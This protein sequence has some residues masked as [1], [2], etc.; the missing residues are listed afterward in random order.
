[1]IMSDKIKLKHTFDEPGYCQKHYR[2]E[3]GYNYIVQY[4]YGENNAPTM[5]TCSGDPDWLEPDTALS[6]AQ[7]ERFE[8][9]VDNNP[10]KEIT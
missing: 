9:P 7:V 2:S 4:D 5:Y 3:R 10:F 6:P 1:M 8:F